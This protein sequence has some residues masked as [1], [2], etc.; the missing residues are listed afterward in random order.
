MA[1]I[2]E[3]GLTTDSRSPENLENRDPGGWSK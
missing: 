2:G 1:I 3:L